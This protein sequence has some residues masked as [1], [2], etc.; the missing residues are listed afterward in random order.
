MINGAVIENSDLKCHSWWICHI[1][2]HN[3][4]MC[5]H[6][7]TL[8]WCFH[9]GT[10]KYLS[11]KVYLTDLPQW[12]F[13]QELFYFSNTLIVSC[14]VLCAAGSTSRAPLSAWPPSWACALW[15]SLEG[16]WWWVTAFI[17]LPAW[18]SLIFLCMILFRSLLTAFC[19]H[20]VVEEQFLTAIE[21][22]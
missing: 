17:L 4:D 7:F 11:F 21:V 14:F 18:P 13:V 3:G 2:R 12:R 22:N 5:N 10:W 9:C 1:I 15:S 19:A 20:Y 16:S 6:N 8:F